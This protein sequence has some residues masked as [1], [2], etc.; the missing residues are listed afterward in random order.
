ML[1]TYKKTKPFGPD[2]KWPTK[3]LT[4]EQNLI[5]L[6]W[7]QKEFQRIAS[8]AYTVMSLDEKECLGC[9]YIYPSSNSEYDAEIVMWVRQSEVGN[10]LDQLLF[11]SVK[12][13]IK[14]EWP[15]LNP[16][17]PGRDIDWEAWTS[18]E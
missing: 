4:F 13:W 11:D 14:D 9:I 7:H 18:L 6:G 15:F 12:K 1:I 16:G 5:D 10:S 17:Y 2:R 3:N 8:F